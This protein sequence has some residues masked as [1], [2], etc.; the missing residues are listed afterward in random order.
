MYQFK[1]RD[2]N[3][4][5]FDGGAAAGGGAAVGGGDSAGSTSGADAS[6]QSTTFQAETKRNGTKG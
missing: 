5:M 6:T 2:I 3:L 1:L 4:K